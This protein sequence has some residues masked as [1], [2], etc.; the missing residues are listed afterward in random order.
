MCEFLASSRCVLP[1]KAA[2]RQPTLDS[3]RDL[4]IRSREHTAK[5][6]RYI[7]P[8]ESPSLRLLKAPSET[9]ISEV[10]PKMR[11]HD[12]VSWLN[13]V[14]GVSSLLFAHAISEN[15]DLKN[16]Q[17]PGSIVPT[18]TRRSRRMSVSAAS[19]HDGPCLFARTRNPMD[20]M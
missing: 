4:A 17:P 15:G 18:N 5:I 2:R 7:S 11:D 12:R 6:M 20:P 13:Q 10:T 8:T 9:A 16:L 19:T 3:A 14:A 1:R